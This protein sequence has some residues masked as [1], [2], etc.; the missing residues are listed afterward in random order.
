MN[1]MKHVIL[2]CGDVG[3]R[4]AQQ[5]INQGV[6]PTQITA[7]VRSSIDQAEALGVKVE[8]LDLDADLPDMQICESAICYYTIAPQKEGRQDRR[9]RALIAKFK[10]Q[11]ITPATF[12]LISTT[13]VYGDHQGEWVDETTPAQPQTERGQRRLDSEQQWMQWG[14]SNQVDTVILRVPG[15][16]AYSRLPVKRIQ[17]G[18]PVVRPQECGFTNRIHADDLA[19]AC[20]CAAQHG[21]AGEVYNATD[22]TPGKISEYLTEAANVLGLPTLPE[23][24]MNEAQ[25]VLSA[26]MLSYLGES[27]KISNQKMRTEL[28]VQLRYP[29]FKDGIKVG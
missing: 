17:A 29:D 24:S 28:K 21:R 12:V 26:S 15:I 20:I 23:I 7:F 1:L 3:R 25:Q 27:R 6:E 19:R 14:K 16:Y 10:E 2:G 18:T 4:I 13:G 5:L 9:S 11:A 22:G 8:R